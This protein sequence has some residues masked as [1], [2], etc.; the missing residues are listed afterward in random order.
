MF[1]YSTL[2]RY[3]VI[4][5]LVLVI[6]NKLLIIHTPFRSRGCLLFTLRSRLDLVADRMPMDQEAKYAEDHWQEHE[7]M[8]HSEQSH[9]KENLE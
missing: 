3:H 1:V 2:S 6:R 9:K 5:T 8:E 7:G 4:I